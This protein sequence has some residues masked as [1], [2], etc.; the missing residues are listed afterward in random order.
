MLASANPWWQHKE[1]IREDEK[2]QWALSRNHRWNPAIPDRNL[3]LIGPRQVGKTTAF[4]LK[5][6]DLI[7][8]ATPAQNIL[9]HSCE[10]FDSK[11]DLIDLVL[12]F[13]KLA[14]GPRHLFLDEVTFVPDWQDSVKFLL[15]SP[16]LKDSTL[17]VTGS[18]IAGLKKESFPGRDIEI[19]TMSPLSFHDFLQLF[20][21][22]ELKSATPPTAVRLPDEKRLTSLIPHTREID[23][24]FEKYL[25]CGGFPP[26]MYHHMEGKR[27][28]ESVYETYGAWMVGDIAKLERSPRVFR[29]VV[30]GIVKNYGSRFSLNSIARETEIGSHVTVREYLELMEGLGMIRTVFPSKRGRPSLRGQRKVYA[31]DPLV[32]RVFHRMTTASPELTG[33]HRRALVE[34]VV[35]EHLARAF[36]PEQVTVHS[37]KKEVDFL[38]GESG[39]EVKQGKARASDFPRIG[40]KNKIL[41]TAGDFG[42]EDDVL[43]SPVSLF[44]AAF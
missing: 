28:P 8:R 42:K 13:D 10:V 14:E 29:A 11:K 20:G 19:R 33:H 26:A 12:A 27:I 22:P 43:I 2:V 41:L 36:G 4:K 39:I 18:T 23:R 15:D 31:T 17:Y 16:I 32:L 24:L 30:S 7:E 6:L 21:S 37:G 40:L 38:V 5:I 3:L 25:Q 1:A 35:G 34:G 44:L 9:Y